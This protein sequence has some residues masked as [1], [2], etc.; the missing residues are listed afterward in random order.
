MRCVWSSTVRTGW[1]RRLRTRWRR[2]RKTALFVTAVI[3]KSRPS[4]PALLLRLQIPPMFTS[5]TEHRAATRLRR[6]RLSN[7]CSWF[8]WPFTHVCDGYHSVAPG[9]PA[10]IGDRRPTR[11][12]GLHDHSTWAF[13]RSTRIVSVVAPWQT[14]FLDWGRADRACP[15][16]G[17]AC[18]GMH[19]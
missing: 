14:L 7:G 10:S 2:P 6:R 19:R 16:S 1:P 9:S 17:P 5:L 11:G 12:R 15:I 4:W 3:G 8:Y 13:C 18:T